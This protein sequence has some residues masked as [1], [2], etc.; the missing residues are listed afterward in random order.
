MTSSPDD[1]SPDQPTPPSLRKEEP[2]V[3]P[4]PPLEPSIWEPLDGSAPAVTPAPTYRPAPGTGAWG[5][6]HQPAAE[7][8]PPHQVAAAY[9]AASAQAGNV[10]VLAGWWRRAGAFLIDSILF[11]IGIFAV[12]LAIGLGAGMTVDDASLF[13]STG[14][15]PDSIVHPVPLYVALVVSRLVLGVIPAIFL[16]RWDGQT[17]GKRA[18]G[19]RVMRGDGAPM[20]LRVA[21]RREVLGRVVLVQVAS[22]VTIGLAGVLNYFWPLWDNQRRAGH[23]LLADTRVVTAPVPK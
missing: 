5:A 14:T 11:G 8:P 10:H 22:L 13:F 1:A 6:P 18:L 20:T 9:A 21:L 17:P 12:M 2:P 4:A 16:V 19:L 3:A 7:P 15:L 23:D